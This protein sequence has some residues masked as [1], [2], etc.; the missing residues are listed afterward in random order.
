MNGLPPDPQHAVLKRIYPWDGYN[1]TLVI[2]WL[3][4]Q[5]RAT[6]FYG[7]LDDFK[8]R[9]G[10]IIESADPT[11]IS[12]LIENYTGSYHVVPLEGIDQILHT[13]NKILTED[14]IIDQVPSELINKKKKYSG[15][16]TVTPRADLYQVLRTKNRDMEGDIIVQEISYIE[17]LNDA[18]GCTVFIA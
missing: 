2:Q 12:D 13:K 8:L 6:G 11:T 17:E 1:K 9:Y 10:A 3:Y 15:P 16:Y 5:A 14:I 7:T 4:A 18:G